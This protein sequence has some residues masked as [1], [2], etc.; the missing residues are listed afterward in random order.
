MLANVLIC[1]NE[2]F[3]CP[4]AHTE[5]TIALFQSVSCLAVAPSLTQLV[6]Q[7]MLFSYKDYN[8]IC[9]EMLKFFMQFFA[10]VY[11]HVNANILST[12][13]TYFEYSSESLK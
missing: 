9:Y 2:A 6:S 8:F 1:L 10:I 13:S 7:Q 5:Y 12:F 11:V 3:G 4:T